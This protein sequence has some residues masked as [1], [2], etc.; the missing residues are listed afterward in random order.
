MITYADVNIFSIL[1]RFFMVINYN[2]DDRISVF[3]V[4]NN[5][6]YYYCNAMRIRR[7]N[8][9]AKLQRVAFS[10]NTAIQRRRSLLR[11]G[12]RVRFSHVTKKRSQRFVAFLFAHFC[13]LTTR[14]PCTRI[15]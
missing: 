2:A 3:F 5:V 12:G 7:I 15:V 8:R 1:L 14:K 10:K 11:G 13:S 6:A 4:C 9:L